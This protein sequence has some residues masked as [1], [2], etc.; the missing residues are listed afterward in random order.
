[1]LN[2]FN[3]I[4][5]SQ[6]IYHNVPLHH[7]CLGALHSSQLRSP[8]PLPNQIPCY[9]MD[10]TLVPDKCKFLLEIDF[11]QLML[12]NLEKQLN[13]VHTVHAAFTVGCHRTANRH[14]PRT[15]PTCPQSQWPGAPQPHPST[16]T[17]TIP[18][19]AT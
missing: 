2:S 9:N 14:L 5:H 7:R 19:H 8:L 3:Y 10:P 18:T 4:S 16:V 12:S 15:R 1:L 13:W 11:E 6:R 17:V